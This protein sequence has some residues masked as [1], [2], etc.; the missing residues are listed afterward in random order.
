M[1][2][3]QEETFGPVLV[4]N[5]IDNLEDAVLRINNNVYG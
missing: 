3:M 5:K 1:K 2:I 4:V